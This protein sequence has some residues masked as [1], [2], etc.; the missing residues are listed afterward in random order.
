VIAMPA[1]V[2]LCAFFLDLVLGDPRWLPHPVRGIGR[3]IQ[4]AERVLRRFTRSPGAEKR[5]GVLLV[6]L[7][8]LPVYGASALLLFFAS[9]WSSMLGFVIAVLLAYTTLAARDL[10]G[11]A[12]TVLVQLEAGDINGARL[13]LSMIV[14]RDTAELDERGITRAVVETVA[15][16]TSDGVIAPLFYLAIGGPALAM[17][18]KAVN[19]LDS[20]VGYKNVAYKNFGWAAARLDDLANF[21]PARISAV[22]LSLAAWCLPGASG[23]NAFRISLRDGRK[24]AS[25]NS[26]YPEAA[27]AG[28]L[29][30]RLGG[31]A[32]YGGLVLD[33]PSIGDGMRDFDK[34]CIEKSIRLMYCA[35]TFAVLAAVFSVQGSS[36]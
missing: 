27:A 6:V 32:A 9:F 26:G 25:P 19:T 23:R 11:S 10:A 17:A 21:V 34:K 13:A 31:P 5:A 18:Y 16:N 29:G 30:L 15:E 4:G 1:M 2:I 24:H 20:M 33:K 3:L 36:G 12:R 7:I 14:G 35:S 22:L 8:V 28:A